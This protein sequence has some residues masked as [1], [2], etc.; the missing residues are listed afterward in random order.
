MKIYHI[1]HIDRLSSIVGVAEIFSDALVSG[2]CIEGTTIG[3][4]EIKRR[5]LEHQ[6]VSYPDITVGQCVPFYFCPRSVMLYVLYRANATDLRYRGG[7]EPI[8]HL[9]FDLEHVIAWADSRERRWLYT[10]SNAGSNYFEERTDLQQLDEL[11]WPAI[12][13]RDWQGCKEGKQAEFLI[14]NSL[15]FSLVERIGVYSGQIERCVR[16]ELLRSSHRPKVEVIPSWY[17]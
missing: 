17:Y 14:E 13:A 11:D 1:V 7:Q 9:E 3:M 8:I 12:R 10:L 16:G 5:R 6:L 15:P 4:D 2:N